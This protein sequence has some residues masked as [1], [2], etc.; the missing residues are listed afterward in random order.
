M[1][2][3]EFATLQ[4]SSNVRII[5]SELTHDG[6]YLPQLQLF[7]SYDIRTTKKKKW[8]KILLDI[9]ITIK[10]INITKNIANIFSVQ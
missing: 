5:N 2:L 8:N 1:F 6:M 3:D 4:P 9:W 10:S 7:R